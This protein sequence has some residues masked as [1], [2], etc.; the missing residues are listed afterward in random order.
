MGGLEISNGSHSARSNSGTSSP[1]VLIHS[2]GAKGVHPM[3]SRHSCDTLASS[4]PAVRLGGM[5]G[6]LARHWGHTVNENFYGCPTSTWMLAKSPSDR[7]S[8]CS[9]LMGVFAMLHIDWRV[10]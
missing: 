8:F 4:L 9:V 2:C 10:E 3:C 1:D 6:F 7:S 5:V